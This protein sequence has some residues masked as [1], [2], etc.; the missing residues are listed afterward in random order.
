MRAL[1][2]TVL[3]S[4]PFVAAAGT[5]IVCP[6]AY[7]TALLATKGVPPGWDGTAHVAGLRLVLSAAGMIV[8]RPD[9]EVQALLRGD[10]KKTA[11]GYTATYSGLTRS[12]EPEGKW[13]F[14]AYGAGADVQLLHRVPDDTARCVVDAR[15]NLQHGYD[16]RV[17]CRARP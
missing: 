7:P 17:T 11:N 8:G 2:V 10:E 16:I 9:R 1:I 14:C 4:L 15:R 13:V 6:D 3:A 12:S 5:T